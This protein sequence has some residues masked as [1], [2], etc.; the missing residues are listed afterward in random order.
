[1]S[2]HN[3]ERPPIYGL[4]AEIE[5]PDVLVDATRAA[6]AE[7]YRDIDAFSPFPIHDVCDAVADGKKS[8]VPLLVLLGG[9]TGASSMFAFQTWASTVAYPFNIGGRPAFSWPAFIPP[10]FEILILLASFAA[11]FGMFMLN[12]LPRPHHPVFNVDAFERATTDRYFL[13]VKSTDAKFDLEA[14][15]AFLE[16]VGSTEVHDVDW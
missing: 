9:L 8:K 13:L 5:E 16:G 7:G 10:T 2:A 11:V 4:L 15:R 12:G 3:S 14:T 6:R 1:M